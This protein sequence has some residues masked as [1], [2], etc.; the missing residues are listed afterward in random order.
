VTKYTSH[1]SPRHAERSKKNYSISSSHLQVET[2][3]VPRGGRDDGLGMQLFDI[4]CEDFGGPTTSNSDFQDAIFVLAYLSNLYSFTIS[5]LRFVAD[6]L[7][8][9]EQEVSR[10]RSEMRSYILEVRRTPNDRRYI[11]A[12]V[13]AELNSG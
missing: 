9:W 4:P 3:S 13:K 6:M 8:E 5:E 12:L 11:E 7:V 1:P 2:S 10:L